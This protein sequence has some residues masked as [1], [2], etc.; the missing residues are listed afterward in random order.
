MR[1]MTLMIALKPE[2]EKRLLE[3]ASRVGVEPGEYACRLLEEHLPPE[4]PKPDLES[5]RFLEEFERE[6]ATDDPEEIA[7]RQEEGEE[8]M[9]NLARSR[10]EMEGPN[11]RKLWP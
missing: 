1:V 2:T 3:Q 11:A 10:I 7:R 4:Q 6:N 5:I 9:R 8:F